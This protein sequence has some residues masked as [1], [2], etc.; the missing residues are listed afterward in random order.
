MKKKTR[1]PSYKNYL[2][3]L[4]EKYFLKPEG[5]NLDIVLKMVETTIKDLVN[6]QGEG[7]M[8]SVHKKIPKISKVITQS[9]VPAR[10]MANPLEVLGGMSSMVQGC[11][12]ANNPYMVKNL[13]PNASLVSLVTDLAVS[14]Y[15]PNAVSGED[16]GQVLLA[17]IACASAIS[18]LAGMDPQ[19]SAGVFT[20][21]GTGTEIYA[22]KIGLMKA[23]PKHGTKGLG[24]KNMVV[25][26]SLPAH[27]AHETGCNWL[28]IG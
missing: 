1:K 13:I 23:F 27:Y 19:K 26:G 10:M 21:G 17:E 4:K 2:K 5:D 14:I 7:P 28:G 12:K 9:S 3:I 20:F 8:Y 16:S 6:R 15:M 11:V 24:N 22:L 18:K 25:I